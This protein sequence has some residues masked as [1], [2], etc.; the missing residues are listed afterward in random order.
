M[1]AYRISSQVNGWIATCSLR[2]AE[3]IKRGQTVTLCI[4]SNGQRPAPT[5]TTS[6]NNGWIVFADANATRRLI[7]GE[8][9]AKANAA[10]RG[11]ALTAD[12]SVRA[13]TFIVTGCGVGLP[14]GNVTLT[15]R[16]RLRGEPDLT[17]CVGAHYRRR[18]S[19]CS[20]PEPETARDPR[21]QPARQPVRIGGFGLMK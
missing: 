10:D 1:S 16:D 9:C 12:N 8:R 15:L 6:W 20:T 3:A 5:G 13:I 7:A 14:A 19:G 4:S 11:N 17:R 2:R 21:A 18:T